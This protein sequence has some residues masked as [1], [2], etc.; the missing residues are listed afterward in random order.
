MSEPQA[1]LPNVQGPEK[2]VGSLRDARLGQ[3][4]DIIAQRR[5]SHLKPLILSN[6]LVQAVPPLTVNDMDL[7]PGRRQKH[8]SMI[9]VGATQC[10]DSAFTCQMLERRCGVDQASVEKHPAIGRRGRA[11]LQ[12]HRDSAMGKSGRINP[13]QGRAIA[14][15]LVRDNPTTGFLD[16][17]MPAPAKFGEQSGLAAARTAGND[18]EAIDE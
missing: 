10:F 5:I 18:D 7:W 9:A 12:R 6:G 3:D 4:Q 16:H 17:G 13:W 15:K 2:G 11:I 14:R 8:P 1:S